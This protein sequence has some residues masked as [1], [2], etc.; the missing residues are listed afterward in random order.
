[1]K[2]I[3][4]NIQNGQ[5]RENMVNALANAGYKVCVDKVEDERLLYNN[6][7]YYV[8]FELKDSQ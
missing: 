3:R 4:V 2:T 5:D 8:C 6:H 1:M 7:R